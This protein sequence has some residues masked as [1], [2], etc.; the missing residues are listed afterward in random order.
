MV[1]AF[2]TLER[3][4]RAMHPGSDFEYPETQKLT[5]PHIESFNSIWEAAGPKTPALMD[6]A[7][8]MLGKHAVYDRKPDSESQLGTKITFW[9]DNVRLTHPALAAREAKSSSRLMYPTECR[10]RAITYRG[11]LTGTVHYRVGDNPE[12]A[13]EK[14]FGLL[15]VMVRSNRCNLQNL[16]PADLIRLREEPEE[17]GGYFIINGNE[18]VVRLLVAQRRNHVLAIQRPSYGSRGPGFTPFATQIRCVRR[19]QTSQTVTMHYLTTGNLLLRFALRKQEYMVPVSLLLRALGGASDREIF[20]AVVGGDAENIFVRDRVELL[21][22]SGKDYG[23]F[24]QEQALAYLGDKFR[25][26]MY[27]PEDMG[28][29]QVGQLLLDRMVLVHLASARDKFSLLAHMVRKL[30]AV[31]SGECQEDNPDTQQMQEVYLPGHLYLGLIK[32]KL[33]DFLLGVRAEIGKDVRSGKVDLYNRRYVSRLF[34]RVPADIGQ[35]AQYFLATGNLV[36]RTGLDMQQVS[37]YTIIAEKLN[38]LRY[39]SHF[40]CIHRGAFFAELK[41]TGVRKLLPEGWGFL[42]PVHTPDGA[43]CGLLNHLAHKCQITTAVEE[44]DG[45]ERTLVRLGVEPGM[46]RPAQGDARLLTVQLDGRI[47]GHCSPQAGARIARALR[48][49]KLQARYGPARPGQ[50]RAAIPFS[51]EIGFV[52]PSHGGQLPGLFLFTTPARFVRPVTHLGLQREDCVGSFEQVYMDIACL[53][54]DVRPGVTTHQELLPTHILSAVA[55]LTPFCDFNQSPRN[56]YQCLSRDHDVLTR[57]GWKRI[58]GVSAADEV[59]TLDLQ[60]GAQEWQPVQRVARVAHSGELF[61]LQSAEL[62][63]VCDASHRWYV[64]S[65]DAPAS[66]RSVTVDD[67]RAGRLLPHMGSQWEQQG[68]FAVHANHAVPLVGANRNEMYAWPECSWLSAADSG[69]NLAW[70]QLIGLVLGCGRMAA[71]SAG[72]AGCRR[73]LVTAETDAAKQLAALVQERLRAAL[74]QAVVSGPAEGCAGSLVWTVGGPLEVCQFFAPMLEGPL[75]FDPSDPQQVQAYDQARYRALAAQQQQQQ[76]QQHAPAAVDGSKPRRWL[77]YDWLFRLSVAQARAVIQG[78]AAARGG[79]GSF[80]Q[81]CVRVATESVPLAHD[82]SVLGLMANAKATCRP[83]GGPHARCLSIEFSAGAPLTAALPQPQAYENPLHDGFIYCLQVA[84]GNFMARRQG[85]PLSSGFFTGNCQMG[86]QTMGTPMQSYPYRTDNKLY[87]LQTGQTP[88]CRPRIY[89]DYGVDNYPNGTNA[90][91]AVIS[92]TG[93]DMED[94]MILNKSAHERGFGYGSIYKTEYVDLGK[95]RKSGDPITMHFGVGRDMLADEE[96]MERIDIDGLPFPGVRVEDGLPLY[97]VVDD[98]RGRTKVQKYKGEAGYVE[99]VRLLASANPEEELQVVA[100][101]F[102]IPRSPVIGDKFSSRHGQKGVCSQKFP[103]IDMPFTESG[104]QPDVIIN[105]HAFPSRMTI[106]MFVESIA[107]KAGALHGV[108]Q[109]ATPFQFTET[110]TAADYFGEQLRK[111]GYNYHGN[112]PMYS[113]VAGTEMRA[114]IYIGVVYYQRLRHMVN[115]KYQV[116]TTGPV[117][118]LTQQPIKGRK[119]GGGIRLGEMERDALIAHGSAYFLQDR[120]MNCSDY[121]LAYVCKCCGSLLAPVAIP[122][123]SHVVDLTSKQLD[124]R[125]SVAFAGLSS[126]EARKIMATANAAVGKGPMDL[127]CRLCQHA[128]GITMVALPYVFRYLATELM[129]MNMKLRLDIK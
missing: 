28:N 77:H 71:G 9:V 113:G 90:V 72:S 46:P 123:T 109:D 39:L 111:A 84:N 122:A 88:I 4:Q 8:S 2:K 67:M 6:V 99:T 114:D 85:G 43:P 117:N 15:P 37:G 7:V 49:L 57:R 59:M 60:T 127:V 38:Y 44:T 124:G 95:F 125:K 93:Y 10:Q 115:D 79:S 81:G 129:S 18:K 19:D 89:D 68:P 105:P 22:R 107:A 86:K 51:M 94:A 23:V 70:C 97:A 12:V 98:V 13:E 101:T 61:R 55:N 91:V 121:S 11:R 45:V 21:L 36:S 24:T 27:A 74:P 54:E 48:M 50:E 52:P 17:M 73:V 82:L 96:L 64:N 53:D 87:R 20:E 100:L 34:A 119:R 126:E 1:S 25:V 33:D 118:P 32:E 102:R 42:C 103:A 5:Q 65:R 108:C 120:L 66:Y 26:V 83:R 112:E 78:L 41:T 69:A 110:N 29:A 80:E 58:C 116:R 35:K 14:Q 104:M 76:Q 56:M 128:D 31:V 106:G 3:Q 16:G 62:D 47:V 75:S 92:Y 40:R 30:Y 63:A